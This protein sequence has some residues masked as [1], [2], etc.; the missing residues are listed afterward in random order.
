MQ[1]GKEKR[2]R[3]VGTARR[4]GQLKNKSGQCE[5][6]MMDEIKEDKLILEAT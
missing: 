3:E 1:G 5:V 6:S 4:R 2:G